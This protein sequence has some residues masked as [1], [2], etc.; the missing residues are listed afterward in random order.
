MAPATPVQ[1]EQ[2]RAGLA[3][4]GGLDERRLGPPVPVH[5]TP[6]MQGRGRPEASGPLDG[7]GRRSLYLAVRRNFA[8]PLLA[9]FDR[10]TPATTIGRRSVNDSVRKQ[11]HSR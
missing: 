2:Y 8:D 5:L 3:V 1:A 10:P 6:F 4:S 7:A 9:V 11:S